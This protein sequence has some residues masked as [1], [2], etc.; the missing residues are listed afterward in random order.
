MK[1]IAYSALLLLISLLILSAAASALQTFD[2]KALGRNPD[3]SGSIIVFETD[4]SEINA[5]LNNDSDKLDTIIRYYNTETKELSSTGIAG[6]NPAIL[7]TN[8]AFESPEASQNKDLNADGDK[9]DTVIVYYSLPDK[10]IIDASADGRTPV[11]TDT[12]IVF[13]TL[14]AET[15]IDYNNDGDKADTIIRYYNIAAKEIINTKQAGTN[16]AANSKYI[17]FEASEKE[18]NEDVNK[19]KDTDDLILRYYSFETNQTS[20]IIAFGQKPSIS[21]E[22]IAAFTV[23]EQFTD[24][25]NG[26]LDIDDEIVMYYDIPSQKLTNTK[27]DGS[28]TSIF[29][30]TIAFAQENKISFYNLGNSVFI[31][32]GIYGKD[33]VISGNKLAFSTHEFFTGDLNEDGD[34]KDTVIRYATEFPGMLVEKNATGQEAINT[35]VIKNETAGKNAVVIIKPA[36]QKNET[37][38]KNTSAANTTTAVKP[39]AKAEHKPLPFEQQQ[40]KTAPQKKKTGAGFFAWLLVILAAAIGAGLVIYAVLSYEK[41]PKKSRF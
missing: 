33:P 17:I 38:S 22:N 23:P 8:I 32:T 13:S 35:A 26:D 10:K 5:D 18:L 12:A 3:F 24:D 2:T 21:K 34:S 40:A 27:V 20:N 11:M 31:Q 4:E 9:N 39:E 6:K 29:G 30:K 36:A 1:K 15:G 14:E 41:K 28:G 37:L 25:L 7:E 16:P 19:D